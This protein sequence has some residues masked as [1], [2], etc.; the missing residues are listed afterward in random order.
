[1][2]ASS[3]PEDV[4]ARL[5]ALA[6]KKMT[7]GGVLL[8]DSREHRTQAQ[9]RTAAG[10]DPFLGEIGLVAFNFAPRGWALCNGQIMSIAQNTALFSLLGTTYGGNGTTTFQ[11]PDLRK[12][13]PGGT[14]YAICY[15]GVFPWRP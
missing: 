2:A 13:A 14:T 6:G 8:I 12:Q 4:K 5:I 11:L 9:N 3:L 15:S 7:A 10:Q 1:M